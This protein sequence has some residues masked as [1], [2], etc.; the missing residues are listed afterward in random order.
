MTAA[1][2]RESGTDIA[3]ASTSGAL[4]TPLDLNE[5]V[6]ATV[7]EARNEWQSHSDFELAL[8][9]G[10]PHV[11]AVAEAL[12]RAIL[13]LIDNAAGAIQE[14]LGDSGSKGTIAISTSQRGTVAQ[15][16]ITDNGS[17]LSGP[18]GD[19]MLDLPVFSTEAGSEPGL[20]VCRAA[21]VDQHGGTLD[22]ETEPGVGTT[23]TVSLPLH[24]ED[25]P[26]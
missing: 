5:T 24:L 8:D 7:A 15:I 9:A 22:F 20:A 21:I 26:K 12:E 13:A 16:K 14:V 1:P 23:V 11:P 18:V 19:G 2:S 10:L 3:R 17:G 25:V 6:R 4:L